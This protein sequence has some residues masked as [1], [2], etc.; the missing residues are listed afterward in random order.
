MLSFYSLSRNT[1]AVDNLLLRNEIE[2]YFINIS[3]MMITKNSLF[4]FTP[5]I[6]V[7]YSYTRYSC[8]IR[9]NISYL[10]CNVSLITTFLNRYLSLINAMLNQW[11]FVLI[12]KVQITYISDLSY[13]MIHQ[14]LE[15]KSHG[16]LISIFLFSSN[17]VVF[18]VGGFLCIT[19]YDGFS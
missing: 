6:F 3:G 10:P 5:W 16:G 8:N 13:Y 14:Y 11:F 9:N 12:F 1:F 19:Y 15:H 4:Q 17:E 7:I 2:L 18:S